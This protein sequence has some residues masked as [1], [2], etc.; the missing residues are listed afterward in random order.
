[1]TKP[2]G[3]ADFEGD[4]VRDTASRIVGSADD[5]TEKFTRLLSYVR[6]DIKFG[7]PR[8]GDLTKASETIRLG[9]GQC[10]TKATLLLALCKATGIPARMHF[11]LISKEIQR[12]FFRGL[13][14]RLMPSEISHSWLEIEIDGEW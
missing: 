12:G 9:L 6:E 2:M 10:N 13:A 14:Y 4:L 1:M 8:D 7:F 11:S 3:L 5:A